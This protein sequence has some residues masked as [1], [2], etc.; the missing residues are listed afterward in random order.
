LQAVVLQVIDFEAENSFSLAGFSKISQ[1][2]E[3]FLTIKKVFV[4]KVIHK[5][6]G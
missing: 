2:D 1:G 5:N 6:C 4:H 3:R